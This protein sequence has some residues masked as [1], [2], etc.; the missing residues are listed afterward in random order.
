ME[1][2]NYQLSNQDSTEPFK[3]RVLAAVAKMNTEDL[4]H[5]E[6]NGLLVTDEAVAESFL[7][8]SRYRHIG[9]ETVEGEQVHVF[10]F[11]RAEEA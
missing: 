2:M 10:L 5:V 4:S 1:N 6:E 11:V 8:D 9:L 3:E 7:A